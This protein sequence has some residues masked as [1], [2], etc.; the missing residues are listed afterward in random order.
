MITE[1]NIDLKLPEN[2]DI[3][4]RITN[5]FLE[6]VGSQNFQVH[7]TV[8]RCLAEVVP[9]LPKDLVLHVFKVTIS[10]IVDQNT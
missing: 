7:S 6:G 3:A 4:K 10:S 2:Q 8:M 1:A 5:K 9:F